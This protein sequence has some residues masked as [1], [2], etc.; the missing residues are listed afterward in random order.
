MQ[1]YVR[2]AKKAKRARSAGRKRK[3]TQ[4]ARQSKRNFE[5]QFNNSQLNRLMRRDDRQ[6]NLQEIYKLASYLQANK[7]LEEKKRQ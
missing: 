1:E 2:S 3:R 6:R 7:Q 4:L 5:R